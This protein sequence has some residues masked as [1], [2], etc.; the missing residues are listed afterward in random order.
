MCS[1]LL[2]RRNL[3]QLTRLDAGLA[4]QHGDEEAMVGCW[5]GS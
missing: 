5:L 2:N 4:K 3:D 1:S